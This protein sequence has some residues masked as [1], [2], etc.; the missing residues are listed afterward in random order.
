MFQKRKFT[1]HAYWIVVIFILSGCGTTIPPEALQWSPESIKL[2]QLQTRKFET[3][4]EAKLLQASAGVLQ[5]LGFNIDESETRLGVLVASKER[6]AT[7][8][9]QVIGSA[10][11]FL[12][13]CAGVFYCVPSAVDDVQKLEPPL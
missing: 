4:N 7:E 9:G 12:L 10:F 2:R 13:T 8:T 1:F 3:I 5:D 11:L 6:D